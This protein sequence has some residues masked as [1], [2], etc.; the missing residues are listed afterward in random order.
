MKNFKTNCKFYKPKKKNTIPVVY[1]NNPLSVPEYIRKS[2]SIAVSEDKDRP[3]IRFLT[4]RYISAKD[5]NGKIIKYIDKY[6]K[7]RTKKTLAYYYDSPI[8]FAFKLADTYTTN[9]KNIQAGLDAN[10]RQ[11]LIV[12]KDEP[13][14]PGTSILEIIKACRKYRLPLP[15]YITVN[16]YNN[17][18]ES[19]SKHY[20]MGWVLNLDDAFVEKNW[21]N[22]KHYYYDEN[23]LVEYLPGGNGFKYEKD[24]FLKINSILP[25]IFN[26]DRN[27][28]GM[29]IKN[30]LA[31]G[32]ET[33]WLYDDNNYYEVIP[34]N[35]KK[36]SRESFVDLTHLAEFNEV[37]IKEKSKKVKEDD[38]NLIDNPSKYLDCSSSRNCYALKKT[39]AWIFRYM[40]T[41]KGK[42]PTLDEVIS[43]VENYE[44]ES[45]VYNGKKNIEEHSKIVS[46]A[47][48]CLNFCSANWDEKYKSHNSPFT[49]DQK[50]AGRLYQQ[51]RS[52]V[53]CLSI[54]NTINENPRLKDKELSKICGC[55]LSR[56][57]RSRNLNNEECMNI[58]WSFITL[59]KNVKALNKEEVNTFDSDKIKRRLETLDLITEAKKWFFKIIGSIKTVY[60]SHK[61]DSNV[62]NDSFKEVKEDIFSY[63]TYDREHN[64]RAS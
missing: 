15:T 44:R 20:Q 3:Y 55:S 34:S 51:A 6:G 11:I 37:T 17:D 60:E 38:E 1:F 19:S 23:K 58:L 53:E 47:N 12:D 5:E 24:L 64:I 21:C 8:D 52:I 56:I 28:K 16:I 9:F 50:R 61:V 36:Y 4:S 14:I 7:E 35:I 10:S 33:F 57:Y 26:G 54:R 43:I 40:N 22:L 63:H 32:Q 29:N 46:L 18:G 39:N 25:K 30:P 49:E 48:G 2:S 27:F 13:Y 31:E 45:L 62:Y 59:Y 42:L 41:N